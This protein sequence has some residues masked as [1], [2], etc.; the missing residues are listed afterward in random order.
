M[1]FDT[2]E[3]V[4]D[5]FLVDIASVA[6]AAGLVVAFAAVLHI[7]GLVASGAENIEVMV[8][9]SAAEHFELA[10]E[11]PDFEEEVA[12][13]CSAEVVIAQLA[14]EQTAE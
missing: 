13:A 5:I 14:V 4:P 6:F 3:V 7:E 9:P 12:T 2:E 1:A 11:V 10:F 8:V